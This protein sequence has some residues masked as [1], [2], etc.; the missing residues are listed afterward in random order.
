MEDLTKTSDDRVGPGPPLSD[1]DK[2]TRLA[3]LLLALPEALDFGTTL[4]ED[5]IERAVAAAVARV[6]QAFGGRLRA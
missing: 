5:R 6:G 2:V 1:S 3:R 4:T